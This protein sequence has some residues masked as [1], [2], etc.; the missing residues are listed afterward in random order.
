MK[1]M[2]NLLGPMIFQMRYTWNCIILLSVQ[3][4]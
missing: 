1:L 3:S 2:E 4:F